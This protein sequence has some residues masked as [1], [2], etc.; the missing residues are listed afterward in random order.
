MQNDSCGDVSYA[1]EISYACTISYICEISHTFTLYVRR[2]L[3]L[4][5]HVCVLFLARFSRLNV[6]G[7]SAKKNRLSGFVPFCQISKNEHKAQI[8]AT[9]PEARWHVFYRN[10]EARKTAIAKLQACCANL[11]SET[12][13]DPTII[14]LEGH[15]STWSAADGAGVVLAI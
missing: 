15:G 2:A 9:P 14:L 1:C 8:T 6:K 3:H 10:E 7:K 12:M 11:P 13:A 4:T 5:F